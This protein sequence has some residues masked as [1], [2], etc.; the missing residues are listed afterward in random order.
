VHDYEQW[1]K[2]NDRIL[3]LHPDRKPPRIWHA[4]VEVFQRADTRPLRVAIENIL[5]ND[6]AS[7]KDP[8]LVGSRFNLALLNHELDAAGS[9]AAALPRK[10]LAGFPLEFSRDF[11]VGV[12]ARLKGDETSARAAFIRAAQNRRRGAVTP[13][14]RGCF[15]ASG[16]R[17]ILGKKGRGDERRPARMELLAVAKAQ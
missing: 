17:C 2:V 6:P 12:V 13:M 10:S 3:A 5:A 1:A 9:L 7:E 15:L 8:F 14:L 16:D 11:W 4:V